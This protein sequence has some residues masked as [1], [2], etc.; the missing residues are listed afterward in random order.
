MSKER[1]GKE[2]NAFCRKRT[3]KSSCAREKTVDIDILMTS[4]NSVR[5]IMQCI[6]IRCGHLSR[7]ESVQSVQMN[8]CQSNICK[9]KG[10]SWLHFNKQ[11]ICRFTENRLHSHC[12]PIS[13]SNFWETLFQ[14]NYWSV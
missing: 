6:K 12:F 13:L 7:I 2:R 14:R 1:K 11:L 10:L 8:I 9:K 5:K 4:R 3:P